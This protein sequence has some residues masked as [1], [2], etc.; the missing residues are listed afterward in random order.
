ML[1]RFFI[2]LV[3]LFGCVNFA[4]CSAFKPYKVSVQQGNIIDA[5][6]VSQL[7]IGMDKAKVEDLLG[8]PVLANDFDKD[9][10]VYV[11]TN[12]VAGKTVATN[13]VELRFAN[14]KLVAINNK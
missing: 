11:Y 6:K 2:L 4:G 1:Q 13:R 9:L 5:D 3:L 7:R 12:Q 10:W 14:D 8:T